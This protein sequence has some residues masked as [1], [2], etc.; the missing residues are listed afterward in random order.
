MTAAIAKANDGRSS[1]AP[2]RSQRG[3][4]RQCLRGPLP[5]PAR[6]RARESLVAIRRPPS[7]GCARAE[8]CPPPMR[9]SRFGC[10]GAEGAALTNGGFAGANRVREG[11][12]PRSIAEAAIDLARK[13]AEGAALTKPAGH[14]HGKR[15]AGR[16]A[17]AC[18][19]S[20][21]RDAV[22]R[23]APCTPRSKATRWAELHRA[24]RSQRPVPAVPSWSFSSTLALARAREPSRGRGR[25]A[26]GARGHR[27]LAAGGAASPWRCR[28]ASL[29][30]PA[31]YLHPVAAGV[32]PT[33]A[34]V[35]AV[36]RPPRSRLKRWA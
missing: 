3:L 7:T 21:A 20:F 28:R 30:K 9:R 14:D 25:R 13:A 5:N 17:P 23:S 19:P 15:R 27:L 32:G 26:T 35:R 4:F 34:R 10:G 8:P 12:A 18:A 22:A 2:R 33:S 31:T 29:T 16:R 36:V 11:R 6:A 24:R 1:I